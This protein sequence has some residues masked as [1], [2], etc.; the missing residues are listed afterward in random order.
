MPHIFEKKHIIMTL[1]LA[2][3]EFRLK[4]QGS[5]LGFL[6]TLLYPLI[7][8]AVLYNIFGNWM[9][10]EIENFA[11]Y[12]IIGIV[13]W[14]FFVTATGNA[15]NSVMR[16]GNFVKN[17]K[18]PNDVLVVSSV[19]SILY[20]HFL[21]LVI[22]LVFWLILGR[23]V[24]IY[25]LFLISILILNIYLTL[26]MGFILATLGVF[27]LDI[28][29]IWEIIASIGLFL[30]PIFYSLDM[31][32]P[33]KRALILINPMTHIITASR[34]VLIDNTMPEPFGLLYVLILSTFLMLF[35]YLLFKHY[36]GYFAEKI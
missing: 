2:R 8:F 16:Q 20:S 25:A 35:G 10:A 23:A 19:F 18:F 4:D 36:E 21:E 29:R 26:S 15:I 34:S 5:F 30:T 28:N 12:L 17:I 13:Q 22:L 7:Y 27:F 1:E 32:D 11:L 24:S 3:A 14:N 31:L 6:W 33:D 9:G